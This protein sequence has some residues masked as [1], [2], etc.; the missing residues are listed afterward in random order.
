MQLQTITI[1]W[2]GGEPLL[3]EREPNSH[4]FKKL[5][6]GDRYEN[7]SAPYKVLDINY[8]NC[9]IKYIDAPKYMV[10]IK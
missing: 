4:I 10:I 8:Y 6:V 1:D 3:L 9:L 2:G 5:Q 7:I